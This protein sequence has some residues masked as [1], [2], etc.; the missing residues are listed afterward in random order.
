MCDSV[1]GADVKTSIANFAI[2]HFESKSD[3][4]VYISDVYEKYRN[5]GGVCHINVF[6]Q[7]FREIC[8]DKFGAE[9]IRRRKNPKDNAQNALC[10]IAWKNI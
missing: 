9:K 6:S 7:Y 2:N 4:I 5:E 1:E 3:S 8:E 10:G